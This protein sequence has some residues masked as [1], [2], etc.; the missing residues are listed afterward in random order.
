MY[1]DTKTTKKA[2]E[3]GIVTGGHLEAYKIPCLLWQ[4]LLCIGVEGD[5]IPNNSEFGRNHELPRHINNV[6]E[7]VMK[8][9]AVALECTLL[10]KCPEMTYRM[11]SECQQ[12]LKSGAVYCNNLFVTNQKLLKSTKTFNGVKLHAEAVHFEEDRKNYGAAIYTDCMS[13]EH[14]HV[15]HGVR[16]YARTSKRKYSVTSEM[17]FNT[18][19]M[20]VAD[21][22]MTKV[23]RLEDTESSDCSDHDEDK[24][25]N[26]PTYSSKQ[27]QVCN[28]AIMFSPTTSVNAALHPFL[29]DKKVFR[30]L[31]NYFEDAGLPSTWYSTAKIE[32]EH[33]VK[34]VPRADAGFNPFSVYCTM[35]YRKL[36]G[37]KI[38]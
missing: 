6:T 7:V 5:I 2:L 30:L 31:M 18:I 9:G 1:A 35:Q 17:L 13:T 15:A 8:A 20:K 25:E 19:K 32:M 26:L 29:N 24:F 3:R 27:V 34:I 38:Y 12:L 14:Q 21:T 10:M 22:L 33:G 16:N 37:G 36:R 11:I 4:V 28:E 23:I